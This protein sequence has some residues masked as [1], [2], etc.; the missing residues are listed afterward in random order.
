MKENDKRKAKNKAIKKIMDFLNKQTDVIN[1]RTLSDK[2]NMSYPTVLKYR[3][4]LEDRGE[5]I[6]KDY[7]NVV[8]IKVKKPGA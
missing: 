4:I 3:D 2:L 8:L 5:I 7:G 6:V 1:L